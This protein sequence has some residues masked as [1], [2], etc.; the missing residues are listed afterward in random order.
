MSELELLDELKQID[1]PTITNVVAT[2][3]GD[4]LCLSLY[5]PW[6]A[7]WYTDNRLMCW[8]PELG[9]IAGYAVTCTY[10]V[11]DPGY[12]G[13]SLMDVLEE[14][15]KLAGP[16][17]FCF[18]QRFPPELADK[19]GLSGGNM[20]SSLRACGAIG[21]VTNGPSRDIH[22]IRPMKFQYLTR[23]ICAGHGSQ[24]IQGVQVPV[25]LCG[26]DVAPGDIVHMDENGA[27]KF[28]ANRLEEV[29]TNAKLLLAKEEDRVG[30]LLQAKGLAEVR[31]IMSGHQYVKK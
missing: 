10:S 14:A 8:Y 21:A 26:M 9:P 12:S 5:H 7:N 4:E 22:E 29:V 15:D 13:L 18:E 1:T 11:T 17:I 6:E 31:A 3:P 28:P 2:Y 20:T 19:V 30:Q 27:V 24:S 25:S 23:G 16:S